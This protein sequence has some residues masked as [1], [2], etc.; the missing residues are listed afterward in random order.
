MENME[1]F[2][3]VLGTIGSPKLLD[4]L[5]REGFLPQNVVR[6]QL[7]GSNQALVPQ[8]NQSR[9]SAS[10]YPLTEC[11][12]K[13]AH[14]LTSPEVNRLA[15]IWSEPLLSMSADKIYSSTHLFQLLQ[16][17]QIITPKNVRPLYDGLHDIGRSDLAQ[18]INLYLGKTGQ[19]R[20]D[21]ADVGSR[22][23]GQGWYYH[24]YPVK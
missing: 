23:A 20:Y 12:M 22:P 5:V 13:I 10:E 16:Q 9:E 18:L 7:A 8:D 6:Q 21:V 11:L 19:E 3:K 24:I 17:R 4:E 1:F 15:F 2:I 14:G